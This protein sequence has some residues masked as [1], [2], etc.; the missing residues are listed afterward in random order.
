MP[1]G[2][3]LRSTVSGLVQAAISRTA[4]FGKATRQTQVPPVAPANAHVGVASGPGDA[5]SSVNVG[6]AGAVVSRT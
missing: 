2:R 6:T 1:S 3:P 4:P 5:G